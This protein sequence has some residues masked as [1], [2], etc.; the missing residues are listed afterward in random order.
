MLPYTIECEACGSRRL[1]RT[2]DGAV[3]PVSESCGVCG[4][5]AYAAVA[6]VD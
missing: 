4:S 3:E 6:P 1:G 2:S 5:E